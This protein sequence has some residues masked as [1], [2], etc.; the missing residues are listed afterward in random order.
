MHSASAKTTEF[1]S[2][3]LCRMPAFVT[4]CNRTIFRLSPIHLLAHSIHHHVFLYYLDATS[5]PTCMSIPSNVAYPSTPGD[6][7]TRFLGS[8]GLTR[9]YH[10]PS[11][12]YHAVQAGNTI[13]LVPKPIFAK[14]LLVPVHLTGG[15]VLSR[16]YY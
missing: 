10:N 1:P 12:P 6:H 3:T 4:V 11:L 13:P 7:P 5:S 16:Y 14:W 9:S 8:E 2:S 15:R